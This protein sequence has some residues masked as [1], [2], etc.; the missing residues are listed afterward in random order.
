MSAT[1]SPPRIVAIIP[2]SSVLDDLAGPAG[3]FD[4][5][6]SGL[7][8]SVRVDRQ[9]DRELALGQ[10]LDRHALACG[11]PLAVQRLQRDRVAGG[12]AGLEVSDVDRLGVR[13]KW[14]E[15]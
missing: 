5:L 9:R 1:L 6:A 2:S 3:G 12:E 8:E 15:G 13:P 7:G 10:D 4:A 14:L 11:Q